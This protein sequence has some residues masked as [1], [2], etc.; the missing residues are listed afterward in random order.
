M[1]YDVTVTHK[2]KTMP[3]VNEPI[4][5]CSAVEGGNVV[6]APEKVGF[7]RLSHLESKEECIDALL[8]VINELDKGDQGVWSNEY[9]LDI[10]KRW[11]EGRESKREWDKI[12]HISDRHDIPSYMKSY[13]EY[14]GY[15]TRKRIRE[16]ATRFLL[17]YKAGYDILLEW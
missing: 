9:C 4:A 5:G 1:G 11:S 17:Y 3:D 16:D 12:S 10:D 13:E 2:D 15:C 14:T 6:M 7:K 8:A